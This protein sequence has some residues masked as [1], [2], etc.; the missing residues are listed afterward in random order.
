MP[1]YLKII[2]IF[3]SVGFS[4]AEDNSL[5]YK[6]DQ[7]FLS[8]DKAFQI[9]LLR[10]E[11]E[12][13]LNLQSEPGYYLYKSKIKIYTNPDLTFELNLPR[14]KIKKDQFFGKQEVYY[15]Q[16]NAIITHSTPIKENQE[17]IIEYQGCSEKGLCYPPISK[18]YIYKN[19]LKNNISETDVII[20]QLNVQ[21]FLTP[22]FG[23]FIAGLLLSLTPCVLPMVPILSGI[24]LATNVQKSIPYTLSYVAGVS[25]TYA[26]LGIIAGLTG[27]LLSSSLQ[28]VN[29]L[30][31]SSFVYF[32]FALAMF[33][34]IKL[35]SLPLQSVLNKYLKNLKTNNIFNIFLLG[36][37]SSLILSPCV[38]PPLAAAILYIGQTKD[39]VL[40]GFSL[41]SMSLGMSMP[42]LV[43]GFSS[44]KFLPKSG[45]WMTAIKRILGFILIG[46]CFYI[47][48]PLL[49][50]FIFL[51]LIS[52][53][54]LAIFIYLFINLKISSVFLRAILIAGIFVSCLLTLNGIK[55]FI[56]DQL[57][58]QSLETH[59]KFFQI[60]NINALNKYL[61]NEDQKPI[62]LDFYADWCIACLEYEKFTFKDK[63]VIELMKNFSL[64]R[65]DVTAN[66]DE[67]NS[68]LQK[69]NLF[70]PPGIIF[71]DSNGNEIKHI[72]T[73][74]FKNPTQF[75]L[76]LKKAIKNEKNK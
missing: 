40:G 70:G 3:F 42:L 67:H 13:L 68:L 43:V 38:A 23:F 14:G 8:A 48:R 15:G 25:F 18:K 19:L 26:S 20:N 37:F 2:I 73:I 33:D 47:I 10:N 35:P 50:E 36:G 72:R 51:T 54:L 34:F 71:F 31:F 27:T 49:N 6:N 39:Y 66:N 63:K 56:K 29:F 57:Q 62:L 32:I 60:N 1:I 4:Y 52:M 24:I 21:N 58:G 64:L 75:S 44:K 76:I 9:N 12:I 53:V 11:N 22:L 65:A 7:K 5:F 16:I 69:F 74:G 61:K 28:N 30:I 55:P 17:F 46:M 41:F 45:P 59:S